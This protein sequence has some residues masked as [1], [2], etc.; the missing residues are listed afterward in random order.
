LDSL[1]PYVVVSI[2]FGYGG[3][4]AGKHMA[5]DS[6]DDSTEHKMLAEKAALMEAENSTLK[7]EKRGLSDELDTVRSE[8]DALIQEH[9][10]LSSRPKRVRE[11]MDRVLGI[12]ASASLD[13]P[14][15]VKRL[16]AD[17]DDDLRERVLEAI[18]QLQREGLLVA[19]NLAGD[20]KRPVVL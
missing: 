5:D 1:I 9:A 6:K 10:L 14:T 12:V 7:E 16:R 20:L 2:L 19:G 8:R 11:M 18:G 4:V 17:N 15:I 3:Y 13:V